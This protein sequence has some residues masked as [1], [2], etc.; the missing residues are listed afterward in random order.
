VSMTDMY[1]VVATAVM[2]LLSAL[3]IGDKRITRI[4][5]L[6]FLIVYVVYIYTLI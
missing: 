6:I 2:L 3:L 5:G 4:E 1:M